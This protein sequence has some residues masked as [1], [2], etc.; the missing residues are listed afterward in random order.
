M[1]TSDL[2][3]HTRYSHGRDSV[4]DM[5]GAA[6]AR[7]LSWLG[8]SEHSPRPEGYTYPVEYRDRLY[9][10]FPS[11]VDEVRS[12]QGAG[13]K[14]TVLLG[15]EMDWIGAEPEFVRK[16]VTAYDFDYLIG[17]VHF[18]DHW[19]FDATAKDWEPLDQS[20]R[21]KAYAAYFAAVA[22]MAKSNLFRV[23]GHLDLIK[24]FSVNDFHAWLNAGNAI[25]LVRDALTAVRD[26]GMAMEISS[27][28][29]RKP[30]AEIY[31]G[32]A[33]MRLAADLRVPVT[34]S[35]DAHAADQV[36]YAFPELAA[37]AASFGYTSSLVFRR[38]ERIVLEF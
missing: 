20:A 14:L 31:P 22:D 3:T 37:Y 10:G 38:E 23:A 16:S 8:F 9:R 21:Y 5:Y 25:D 27:A 6:L 30:C 4:A 24:I 7:D 15:M 29:L 34:F 13:G 26:A 11:Y 28:G 12:L 2:H 33:I 18:L 35:S 32:P 1:I 36:A 19:G 17:S